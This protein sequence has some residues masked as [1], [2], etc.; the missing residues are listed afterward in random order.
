LRFLIL[1]I[2]LHL[3]LEAKAENYTEENK[4]IATCNLYLTTETARNAFEN[5]LYA[6]QYDCYN[7]F[8]ARI[9]T[10]RTESNLFSEIMMHFYLVENGLLNS[11]M[12]KNKCSSDNKPRYPY[13]FKFDFACDYSK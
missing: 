9:I 5:S 13:Y 12:K 10:W 3:S 11:G 8:Q 1:F 2:C 6:F 4:E 7:K